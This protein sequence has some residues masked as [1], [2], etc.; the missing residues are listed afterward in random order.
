M[1][2][3]LFSGLESYGMDDAESL[4]PFEE[5]KKE[6]PAQTVIEKPIDL[7]ELLYDRTVVCP[8]CNNDMAV[9][10]IKNGV[11]KL[12][13]TATN[14]RP[15]YNK[16][17][18]LL[19]DVLFCEQCGYAA[20]NRNFKK[21]SDRQILILKEKVSRKYVKRLF[22]S[23]YSYEVAL[24]R[25]Q[26]ALYCD[27]LIGRRDLDKAYLC[28]KTSWV[29]ESLLD[30]ARETADYE[31][32]KQMY[33]AYVETAY[34][35]FLK[36]YEHLT[37]PVFGMNKPTYDYMLASLSYEKGD[38]KQTGFWLGKVMLSTVGQRRLKDKARAL[39]ELID[40]EKML[41]HEAMGQS[42]IES[43]GE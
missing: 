24:E 1:M 26:M 11:N 40:E 33:Q 9:K 21:L 3:S 5:V 17:D 12:E 22:P 19:Y 7:T 23:L 30:Q 38:L 29:I 6:P 8:C 16:I 28:L 35:G 4:H 20:L 43:E 34:K 37:F 14:L 25:Y 10:T 15:I 27:T 18:P 32:M 2:K 42:G 13:E 31:A 39:K 36:A 41:R